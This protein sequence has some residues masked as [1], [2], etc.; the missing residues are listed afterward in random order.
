MNLQETVSKL[1]KKE[2]SLEFAKEFANTQ[3][4]TLTAYLKPKEIKVFVCDLDM[5]EAI[6][7]VNAESI[8]NWDGNEDEAK[9]FIE[10]AKQE[11]S[12]YSLEGFQNTINNDV[13]FSESYVFITNNY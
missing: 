1:S 6:S 2:V 10:V 13:N 11:G 12:V 9:E 4:G 7:N 8:S 3:F 5:I